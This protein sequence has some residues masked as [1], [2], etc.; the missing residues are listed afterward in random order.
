[1]VTFLLMNNN[2][3]DSIKTQLVKVKDAVKDVVTDPAF[4]VFLLKVGI[5]ILATRVGVKK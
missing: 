4:G 5:F 3:K 1:M 2:I